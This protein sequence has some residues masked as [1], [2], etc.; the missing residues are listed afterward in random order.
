MASLLSPSP[1]TVASP[2]SQRSTNLKTLT[3]VW[4]VSLLLAL[5]NAGLEG[6]LCSSIRLAFVPQIPSEA[7]VA[8]LGGYHT[9]AV[10]THDYSANLQRLKEMAQSQ[11]KRIKEKQSFEAVQGS[12]LLQLSTVFPSPTP[13]HS[14]LAR[15]CCQGPKAVPQI[16]FQPIVSVIGFSLRVILQLQ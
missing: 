7:H 4:G 11:K 3:L 1:T 10:E 15:G 8:M 14:T 6:W 12:K 13:G 16:S 9:R 2:L 5:E